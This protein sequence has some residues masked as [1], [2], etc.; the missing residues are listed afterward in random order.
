MEPD[1]W[2]A[3]E[4]LREYQDCK[5]VNNNLLI[6]E[7]T[8]TSLLQIQQFISDNK[9]KN[10]DLNQ[11]KE[12]FRLGSGCSSCIKNIDSWKDLLFFSK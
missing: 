11:I 3:L 8:C 7:C 5:E 10:L 1:E 4:E 6:C 12:N 9:L 2:E